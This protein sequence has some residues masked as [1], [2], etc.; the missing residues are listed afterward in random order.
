MDV[1]CWVAIPGMGGR[2]SVRPLLV[3]GDPG[4]F[5]DLTLASSRDAGD[6]YGGSGEF[7]SAAAATVLAI[8][9]WLSVEEENVEVD[10]PDGADSD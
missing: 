5:A 7:G 4:R 1:D 10:P 3:D 6:M 8:R 9:L 2:N